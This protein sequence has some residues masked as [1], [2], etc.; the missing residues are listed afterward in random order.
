MFDHQ[1]IAVLMGWSRFMFAVCLIEK[2]KYF[3]ENKMKLFAK[4]SSYRTAIVIEYNAKNHRLFTIDCIKNFDLEGK[5]PLWVSEVL[6]H[7]GKLVP[8]LEF[9]DCNGCFHKTV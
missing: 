6:L 2:K 7:T 5:F 9:F 4:I 3:K 8:T 1:V